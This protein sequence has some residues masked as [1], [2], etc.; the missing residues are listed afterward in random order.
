MKKK[1]HETRVLVV[2]IL[3]SNILISNSD[4]F[5]DPSAKSVFH[6]RDHP[7]ILIPFLLIFFS[8]LGRIYE[9]E[10]SI[11]NIEQLKTKD[12]FNELNEKLEDPS[13]KANLVIK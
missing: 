8:D 4:I 1:N 12:E 5:N 10:G 13:E 11:I 3:I 2:I 6:P 9:P 7:I